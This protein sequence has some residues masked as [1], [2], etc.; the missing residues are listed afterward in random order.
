M[1][2]QTLRWERRKEGAHFHLGVK[3]SKDLKILLT[4]KTLL[5]KEANPS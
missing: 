4:Q 3:N 5:E 1:V 2:N